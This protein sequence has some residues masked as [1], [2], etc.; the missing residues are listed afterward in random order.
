MAICRHPSSESPEPPILLDAGYS[1]HSRTNEARIC[2]QVSSQG[3]SRSPMQIAGHRFP[4]GQQIAH[5][6]VPGLVQGRGHADDGGV[7]FGQGRIVRRSD[8][9][10]LPFTFPDQG[11]KRA[12]G[13]SLRVAWSALMASTL[14]SGYLAAVHVDADACTEPWA[15]P[16][17]SRSRM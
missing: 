13:M 12:L 8:N 15:E 16:G 7:T 4:S 2:L 10:F 1:V 5:I 14:A 6:R 9:E 17:R 3:R 11:A